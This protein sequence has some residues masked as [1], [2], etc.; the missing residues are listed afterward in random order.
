MNFNGSIKFDFIAV[1]F[2]VISILTGTGYVT[3]K[4][5]QWGSFS[6]F[7][8]LI[9]MLKDKLRRSTS[10]MFVCTPCFK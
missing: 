6:L 5:D 4:F 2:N 3:G 1:L 10:L 7:F 8:F 9:L